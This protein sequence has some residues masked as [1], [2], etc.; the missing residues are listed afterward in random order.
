MPSLRLAIPLLLALGAVACGP[1]KVGVLKVTG[2]P[3]DALVTV[4]DEYLGTLARLR[5]FGIKVSEGE[6]RLT[7]E[8]DDRFPHDALVRVQAD[9]TVTVDVKLEKVP[10]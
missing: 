10:D 4:D 7:V 9:Q 5:R 1:P 2:S 6:H 8:A 3:D